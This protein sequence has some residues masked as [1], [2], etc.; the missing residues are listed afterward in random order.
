MARRPN[1]LIFCVDQMQSYS[2]GAHGNT[3]VKTPT[4]D[5]LAHE[6]TTFHRAY[7]V[8]PVCMPSRSSIIT[9]LTPRQHG[10]LTNGTPL[11]ENIP[12]VPGALAEAGYR[13]HSVGKLHLQSWMGKG[14]H[15]NVPN[16]PFSWEDEV[17]WH[18]GEIKSLPHPYYGFQST[19]FLGGH[20]DYVHGDYVTWLLREHPGTYEKL[21]RENATQM[22]EGF[23]RCW[24]L[25]IPQELHYNNWIAERTMAFLDGHDAAQ[26]FFLWCSFPDPHYPFA[27]CYPYS[28][29][30]DPASLSLSPTRNDAGDALPHLADKRKNYSGGTGVTETEL[31]EITAQTYGMISHVDAQ[32]GRVLEHLERC[33]QADNTVVAFMS[34]HGEYLGA[35][36]LLYKNVWPYEELYR[37]PF[38]WKSP[39]GANGFAPNQPVSLLDFAPTVLDYA[40]VPESVMDMR[41]YGH[42]QRPTLPGCSLRQSIDTGA[43]PPRRPVLIEFDE[44]G[45]SEPMT[46]MRTVIDGSYKLTIYSGMEAGLLF[47]LDKDPGESVNRWDDSAYRDVRC[48]LLEKLVSELARTDRLDVARISGA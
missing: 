43:A 3:D 47:D 31:S 22:V 12:T 1:F 4:L 48:G 40:G 24:Q 8:N 29:M 9:G 46:R 2:I 17:R 16:I 14:P 19:D 23:K 20:V 36:N 10:A 21:R 25:S 6:G 27:A 28:E 45:K 18:E 44:D 37:V 13:T 41:K 35:H 34:D 39:G 15:R 30:Y 11:P 5:H 32:I 33:G 42:A 38:L 26:N 7:C